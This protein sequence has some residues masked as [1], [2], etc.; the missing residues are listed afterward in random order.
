MELMNFSLQAALNYL[1]A[2]HYYWLVVMKFWRVTL[3]DTNWSS[4]RVFYERAEKKAF[5][6]QNCLGEAMKLLFL[7]R[8]N[9]YY[10]DAVP[11]QYWMETQQEG[12]R[13]LRR[14]VQNYE[15]VELEFRAPSA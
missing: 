15:G 5:I 12:P 1:W 8:G 3:N 14:L 9:Q 7:S 13:G 6:S 4:L 2:D 10:D 11:S